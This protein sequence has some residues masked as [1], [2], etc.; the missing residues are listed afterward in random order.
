M[1]RLDD[2]FVRSLPGD[3]SGDRRSRRVPGVAYSRVLPTPVKAPRGVA[4]SREVASLLEL[5]WTEDAVPDE[6]IAA[7]AGN[8]LFERS[9]PY[10]ARYGGHQFGNWAGQ[11]GDGRAITLGERVTS[12]GARFEVQLKGAGPTPYSRGSDGRAVLRSSIREFLCSEAMHH[13]GVPTTRALSLVATG[14]GVERDMFYDGHPRVEPGAVVCRVAPSFLRF[15]SFEILRASEELDL[16]RDL[17]N[18]TIERFFPELGP[19]SL[20][21]VGRWFGEVCRRT[22]SLIARWMRVGF[23]HGVMNTDNMSVLGLTL[24]YGPYGWIDAFDPEW[25]PNTSDASNRRYRYGQQ[26]FIGLWNL[27]QLATALRP[28]VPDLDALHAGLSR[29]RETYNAE[30]ERHMAAR[31]GL[32]ALPDATLLTELHTLFTAVETDM[33]VF[34]RRLAEVTL[35]LAATETDDVLTRPLAA[36]WYAPRDV[37]AAHVRATA[38]WVRRLASAVK[39]EGTESAA[40]RARMRAENPVYVLRNYLAQEAIEAAEEGDPSKVRELLDAMRRPFDEQDGRAHLAEKRPEHARSKPGCSAL[41][42]SS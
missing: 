17:A 4:W 5:P 25:T 16:L 3:A 30:Y 26:P 29:Y 42:C 13:L 1:L 38:A 14:E 20:D 11:L 19:P 40:W 6:V 21:R 31:M 12:T 9:V 8:G 32:S 34:F 7:L 15:G 28:L 18:Y 24:D 2:D 10:A 39:A 37:S 23:V 36:S 27:S 22:G 35:D 33:T 41:S